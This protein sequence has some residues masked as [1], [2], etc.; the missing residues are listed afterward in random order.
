MRRLIKHLILIILAVI[1]LTSGSSKPASTT[2]DNPF[3][4]VVFQNVSV[5]FQTHK[6]DSNIYLPTFTSCV[7]IV[8]LP[9]INK[10][11]NNANKNCP[12]IIKVSK[13][14]NTVSTCLIYK[15][16]LIDYSIFIKPAH[17]LISL[18]KL[19]I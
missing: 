7:E 12:T 2:S 10:R 17:Q 11:P 3:N 18:G 19:I 8:R 9:N 14:T 5:F 13:L 1:T 4:E 6:P 16:S 15:E